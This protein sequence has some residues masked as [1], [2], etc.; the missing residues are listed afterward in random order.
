M[1]E[2]NLLTEIQT[3][4]ENGIDLNLLEEKKGELYEIRREKMRGHFVRSKAKWIEEGEKPTN[5]FCN[6]ESRHFH[7]KLITSLKLDNGEIVDDQITFF[8]RQTIFMLIFTQNKI[9][10]KT[11]LFINFN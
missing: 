11:I 5:Y 7:N 3:L 8:K 9:T 10:L 1:I 4:E 2:K 6:L